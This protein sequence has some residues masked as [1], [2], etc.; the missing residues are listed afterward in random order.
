M[1]SF[2]AYQNVKETECR[3]M[4]VTQILYSY[5]AFVQKN[6]LAN[7]KRNLSSFLVHPKYITQSAKFLQ[8]SVDFQ[9]Q[10]R[11]RNK[12]SWQMLLNQ[13]SLRICVLIQKL[14]RALPHIKLYVKVVSS[15]K[16]KKDKQNHVFDLTLNKEFYYPT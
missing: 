8:T 1:T 9:G 4:Q 10:T 3:K 11:I 15:S 5:Y 12:D 6:G 16:K 2:E 7:Y 13:F 14:E